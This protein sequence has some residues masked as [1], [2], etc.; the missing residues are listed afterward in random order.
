MLEY[1]K[2]IGIEVH[3][4]LKSNTK[5]FSSSENSYGIKANNNISLIDLAYPGVLPSVNKKAID[6]AIK[7]AKVLNCSINRLMHFDRKNY[8]YPDLP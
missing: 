3:A 2:T 5:M 6:L 4:E 8:F 7:A 1:K